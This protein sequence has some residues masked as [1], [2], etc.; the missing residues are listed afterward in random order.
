MGQEPRQ[1]CLVSA[2]WLWSLARGWWLESSTAVIPEVW[3]PDHPELRRA[4]CLVLPEIYGVRKLS[5]RSWCCFNKP[6]GDSDAA[7][8]WEPLICRLIS[9]SWIPAETTLK[10]GSAGDCRWQHLG[11]PLD[12]HGL[13][14]VWR[15][16]PRKIPERTHR[17]SKNP[18]E[19]QAERVWPLLLSLWGHSV[20]LSLR[21][22]DWNSH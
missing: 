20:S 19:N 6:S 18:K 7:K 10:V 9:Q 1:G 14:S 17:E 15:G 4:N 11:L 16:D 13:Y 21:S 12:M 2:P 8:I 5:S 22:I 3:S